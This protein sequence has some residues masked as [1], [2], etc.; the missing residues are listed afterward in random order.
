MR[1]LISSRHLA[2]A[3]DAFNKSRAGDFGL[4]ANDLKLVLMGWLG[5][6]FHPTAQN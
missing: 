5:R 6:I 3:L 4:L 2:F 1:L